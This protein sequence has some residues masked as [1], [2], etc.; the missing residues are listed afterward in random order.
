MHGEFLG[1]FLTR[2]ELRTL[3]RVGQLFPLK[4]VTCLAWAQ[5]R[6]SVAQDPGRRQG[7]PPM[8]QIKRIKKGTS[9]EIWVGEGST[10]PGEAWSWG[11]HCCLRSKGD[12]GHIESGEAE[13]QQGL[14]AWRKQWLPE[15]PPESGGF[16][17]A[18]LVHLQGSGEGGPEGQM[19]TQRCKRGWGD[20]RLPSRSLDQHRLSTHTHS[21]LLFLFSFYWFI[22]IFK[23]T[24]TSINQHRWEGKV[25]ELRVNVACGS[26]GCRMGRRSQCGQEAWLAPIWLV[27]A[28]GVGFTARLHAD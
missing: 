26:R 14:E 9:P 3:T 8:V 15:V 11:S 4:L 12:K 5:R 10:G 7:S 1:C 21:S 22:I 27:R 25:R 16:L 24:V 20:A 18:S 13:P 17:S 19:E 6:V 23:I 28:A 2:L